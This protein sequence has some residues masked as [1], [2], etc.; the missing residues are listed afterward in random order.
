MWID[1]S[2]DSEGIFIS[3]TDFVLTRLKRTFAA[4]VYRGGGIKITIKT[5]IKN[6]GKDI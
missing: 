1:V 5:K 3:G 6:I 2:S 4:V